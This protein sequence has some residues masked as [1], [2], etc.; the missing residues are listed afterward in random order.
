VADSKDWPKIG[1]Q[2]VFIFRVFA[3]P[4]L[5]SYERKQDITV[6]KRHC[7]NGIFIQ[8]EYKLRTPRSGIGNM[9]EFN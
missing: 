9:Y 3:S 6:I 7:R 1:S 4:S 5:Q 8:N 2:Q